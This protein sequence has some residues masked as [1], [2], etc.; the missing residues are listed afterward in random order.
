LSKARA[1]TTASQLRPSALRAEARRWCEAYV[2]ARALNRADAWGPRHQ[3]ALEDALRV[4]E[5]A[6]ALRR[7][8]QRVIRE[9]RAFLRA[10]GR[11]TPSIDEPCTCE[12][13]QAIA[14]LLDVNPRLLDDAEPTVYARALLLVRYDR[15][16]QWWWGREGPTSRDLAVLSVLAGNADDTCR[17]LVAIAQG[18]RILHPVDVIRSEQR[19]LTRLRRRTDA[20][21]HV[22]E[23]RVCPA[24]RD[25]RVSGIRRRFPAL[26]RRARGA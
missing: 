4:P 3:S 5:R 6:L 24:T 2:G 18:G 20:F 8:L 21:L 7:R 9:A 22:A 14:A 15:P 25:A 11:R 13:E 19:K 1:T 23:E 10:E 17:E 16:G 26:G 12:L